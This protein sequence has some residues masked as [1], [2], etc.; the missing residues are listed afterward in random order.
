MSITGKGALSIKKGKLKESLVPSTGF[1]KT[2]AL[3]KAAEGDSFIDLAALTAPSALEAPTYS[4]P[5]LSDLLASNLTQFKENVTLKSKVTGVLLLD[6]DW[7]VSGTSRINLVTAAVADEIFEIIID[8]NARTGISLVD[9]QPLVD[10]DEL[11][12][13]ATDFNTEPFELHAFKGKA[14][15]AVSVYK[16]NQLLNP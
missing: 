16:E 1:K 11:A 10:S 8:H 7:S 6:V 3:H 13:G 15:G 12:I 5:S 14:H 9:A 4:A 2:R